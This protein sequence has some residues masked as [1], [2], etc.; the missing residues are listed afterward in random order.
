MLLVNHVLGSLDGQAPVHVDDSSWDGR[1]SGGQDKETHGAGKRLVS[2]GW[3]SER[4]RHV[5]CRTKAELACLEKKG[6][7]HRGRA[8]AGDLLDRLL[9]T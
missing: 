5:P 2:H 1:L 7:T 9:G 4:K 6:E 8:N 3:A